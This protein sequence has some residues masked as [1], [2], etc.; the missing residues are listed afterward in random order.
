MISPSCSSSL[1]QKFSM[2][3]IPAWP[4][5]SRAIWSVLAPN[6]SHSGGSQSNSPYTATRSLA[7]L[8]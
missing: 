3:R 7:L 2:L 6:H 1:I 4:A 5:T 8:S